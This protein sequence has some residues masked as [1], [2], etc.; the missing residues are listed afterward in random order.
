M[1]SLGQLM[2]KVVVKKSYGYRYHTFRTDSKKPMTIKSQDIDK[3]DVCVATNLLNNL[4]IKNEEDILLAL[5]SLSL[6]GAGAKQLKVKGELRQ[7]NMYAFRRYHFYKIMAASIESGIDIKFAAGFDE[8][9][10]QPVTYVE[11]AGIQFS[12]HINSESIIDFCKE[13]N[14]NIINETD[15][16]KNFATQNGAKEMFTYALHLKNLSNTLTGER[17]KEYVDFLM[18]SYY[19]DEDNLQKDFT[20]TLSRI[21][22]QEFLKVLKEE[23]DKGYIF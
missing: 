1:K 21:T 13:N 11:L 5:T 12:F 19:L 4:I 15:W 20:S 6:L 16:N 3:I 7:D 17:P 23:Y 9:N 22:E 10:N 14:I 8:R 2:K 18:K